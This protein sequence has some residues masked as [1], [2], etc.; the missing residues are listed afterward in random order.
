MTMFSIR[1][2]TKLEQKS[3]LVLINIIT[4]WQ[5]LLCKWKNF[6]NLPTAFHVLMHLANPLLYIKSQVKKYVAIT[7]FYVVTIPRTKQNCL[8][9]SKINLI[10]LFLPLYIILY[11]REYM[12]EYMYMCLFEWFMHGWLWTRQV[13]HNDN[14]IKYDSDN[15]SITS[16]L[17]RE[18]STISWPRFKTFL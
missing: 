9:L 17:S 6:K 8:C 4:N 13:I 7:V 11:A 15:W 2:D 14:I 3:H 16:M 12:S 10:L 18:T 1:F 5:L